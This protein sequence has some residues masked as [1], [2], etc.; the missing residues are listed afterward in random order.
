VKKKFATTAVRFCG[1]CGGRF[2]PK[3]QQDILLGIVYPGLLIIA[4]L[5]QKN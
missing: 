1:E 3:S 4:Y 5:C 2:K